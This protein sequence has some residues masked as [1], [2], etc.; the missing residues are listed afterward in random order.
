MK[1]R[2][3]Y[4]RYWSD[5]GSGFH[6]RMNAQLGELLDTLAPPQSD[7]LD[8]GCGDGRTVGAW[9]AKQARSYVGVDVS[10]TAVEQARASGLDARLIEDAADLPFADASFDFAACIEVFEHLFDAEGAA[11]EIARVLRPGG[12]LLAQVPNVAHWRHRA[13][14][15]LRGRFNPIGDAESLTR[16]W[17]DPHIRFFTVHTLPRMLESVQLEVE[18]VSGLGVNAMCDLPL[19]GRYARERRP[20]PLMQRLVRMHPALFGARIRVV[21]RRH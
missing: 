15:A 17:R 19:V 6:G 13:D 4:E 3:Y 8:V 9:L 21:A 11:G 10:V 5:A 18:Q 1:V 2:D 14:F 20:G 7:C 12:R 16:T